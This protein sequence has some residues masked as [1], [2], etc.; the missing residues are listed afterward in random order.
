MKNEK[1]CIG[2]DFWQ[3]IS[4]DKNCRDQV[5]E[6]IQDEALKFSKSDDYDSIYDALI[7]QSESLDEYFSEMYGSDPKKFWKNLLRDIYI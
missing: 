1:I 7:K 3:F 5:L 4:G 6:L 2:R